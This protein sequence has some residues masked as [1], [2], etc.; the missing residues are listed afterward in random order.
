MKFEELMKKYRAGTATES[1]RAQVE[2][3]VEKVQLIEEYLAEREDFP[4]PEPEEPA[5]EVRRLRKAVNRRTRFGALW[6]VLIV[7]LLAAAAQFLLFPALNARVFDH[8]RE[9][10]TEKGEISEYQL[11]M[12]V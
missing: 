4:L 5:P 9:I 2:N 6:V 7:L 12:D 1:E 8:P 3:D 10:V 11:L